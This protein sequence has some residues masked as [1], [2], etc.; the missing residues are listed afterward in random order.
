MGNSSTSQAF[1]TRAS[2][3]PACQLAKKINLASLLH[4]ITVEMS[5]SPD[6]DPCTQIKGPRNCSAPPIGSV[7]LHSLDRWLKPDKPVIVHSKI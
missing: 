1:H 5:A 7:I 3:K 6:D 2:V 4:F